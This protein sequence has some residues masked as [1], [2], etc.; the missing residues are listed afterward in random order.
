MPVQ[1][2][3]F[4]PI[5]GDYAFFEAHSTEAEMDLRAYK[6]H[7]HAVSGRKGFI[8]MLDFGAGTGSFTS[9]LLRQ[10]AW[11]TATL[12]LTLVEPGEHA[13][14]SA[15][16]NL[17]PFSDH[18]IAH[19]PDLPARLTDRFDFILANHV[20]YYVS[21]LAGTLEKLRH[22]CRPSGLFL[23]A[24]AGFENA[25]IQCWVTGFGL[26]GKPIPFHTA[27]D[28]QRSLEN[29]GFAYKR[30]R[31]PYTIAFPDST[32]N[33]LKILR[34]LFGQQLAGM[35]QPAL[36]NF[37]DQYAQAGKIRIETSHE[38]YEISPARPVEDIY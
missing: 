34:F 14:K 15:L 29:T 23:I 17:R 1:N 38:L 31:V 33:R 6:H 37:F 13:R 26:A 11:D 7:L 18:S 24:M 36:L 3:S 5:L 12:K 32:E 4:D 28:L 16:Q 19:Y 8:R 2:N 21:N 25:L 30:E 35:P 27:E 22:Y 20:F 10:A 9:R